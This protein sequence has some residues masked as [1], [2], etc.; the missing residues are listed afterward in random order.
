MTTININV[1]VPL[2]VNFEKQNEIT[3][4]HIVNYLTNL[5]PI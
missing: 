5:D 1:P 3:K 4:Q 2:P